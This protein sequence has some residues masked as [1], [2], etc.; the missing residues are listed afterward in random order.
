M[1]LSLEQ[2]SILV[3][4]HGLP[5]RSLRSG[6]TVLRLN[7]SW[8]ISSQYVCRVIFMHYCN[9]TFDLRYRVPT[10]FLR[11]K[12]KLMQTILFLRNP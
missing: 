11:R 12:I 9:T 5:I 6:M 10:K 8:V 1:S 7:V 2:M 3:R 4:N